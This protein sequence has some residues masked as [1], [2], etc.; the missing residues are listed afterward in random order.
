MKIKVEYKTQE[1]QLKKS[2]NG[3]YNC[4]DGWMPF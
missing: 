3:H 2:Y 1:E 4:L